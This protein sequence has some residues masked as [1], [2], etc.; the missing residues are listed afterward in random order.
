[1]YTSVPSPLSCVDYVA[2]YIGGVSYGAWGGGLQY[3]WGSRGGAPVGGLW[4][5]YL[6]KLSDL[7]PLCANCIAFVIFSKHFNLTW[8]H[9]V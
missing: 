3:C 9:G 2:S 5:K 4:V 7:F 1:M 6:Y 8:A